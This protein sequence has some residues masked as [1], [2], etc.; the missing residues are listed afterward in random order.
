LG[1]IITSILSVQGVFLGAAYSYNN[2]KDKE[3]GSGIRLK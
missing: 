2:T 1:I 3:T